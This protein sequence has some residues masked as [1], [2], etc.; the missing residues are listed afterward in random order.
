MAHIHQDLT[1]F[2]VFAIIHFAVYDTVSYSISG[3]G[4]YTIQMFSFR[5]SRHIGVLYSENFHLDWTSHFLVWSMTIPSRVFLN[6]KFCRGRQVRLICSTQSSPVQKAQQADANIGQSW[7]KTNNNM[8]DWF[9]FG[10][11]NCDQEPTSQFIR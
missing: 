10:D 3:L 4:S 7:S 11:T 1:N 9:L 8:D 5:F 6:L 2:L